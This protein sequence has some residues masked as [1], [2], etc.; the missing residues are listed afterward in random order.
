MLRGWLSPSLSINE[1][2]SFQ[3]DTSRRGV[4]EAGRQ[5]QSLVFHLACSCAK[6]VLL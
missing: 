3:K 4:V 1:L 2:Q 5:G 6:E